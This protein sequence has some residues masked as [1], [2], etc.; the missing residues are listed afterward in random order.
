[1]AGTAMT[2]EVRRKPILAQEVA[3]A[4]VHLLPL[5]ALYTGATLFDWIMC[6]I[7]LFNSDVLGDWG[8]SSIFCSQVL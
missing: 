6:A 8:I 3:F 4:G 2:P 1:M 5:G 7:S